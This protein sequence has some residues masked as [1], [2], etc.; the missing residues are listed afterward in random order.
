LRSAGSCTILTAVH[1]HGRIYT[2]TVYHSPVAQE[3]VYFRSALSIVDAA[4]GG[5]VELP[6]L[7][8]VRY[9]RRQCPCIVYLVRRTYGSRL[10]EHDCMPSSSSGRSNHGI[11]QHSWSIC[12][13]HTRSSGLCRRPQG[14][15]Q[16]AGGRQHRTTPALAHTTTPIG[17]DT[18]RCTYM[19]RYRHIP[20]AHTYAHA[21]A[22]IHISITHACAHTD[23]A[24]TFASR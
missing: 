17:P 14:G 12:R 10:Y 2:C 8:L 20:G 23:N 1:Q 3:S 11:S 19:P 15:V 16:S 24:H 22:I 6:Q 4:A 5:I 9:S 7:V 21:H 18:P 13:P